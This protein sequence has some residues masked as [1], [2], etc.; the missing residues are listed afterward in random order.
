MSI[1]VINYVLDDKDWKK[2]KD[3]LELLG[4]SGRNYMLDTQKTANAL[5][6]E[7]LY[8]GRIDD[9]LEKIGEGKIITVSFDVKSATGNYLLVY[10]N[11]HRHKWYFSV[12]ETTF[13]G[14]SFRNFGT[15][16]VRLSFKAKVMFS[17]D[18]V[19]N[20]G[21]TKIEFF[22]EYN[23]GNFFQIKNVKI[24]KGDQKT[25]YLP[26]PEDLGVHPF[27]AEL[28]ELQYETK[29]NKERLD[30]LEKATVNLGGVV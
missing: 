5:T 20:H 8:F 10:N 3:D 11:N 24:E 26:A 7:H 2:A 17:E 4:E 30:E 29:R 13:N 23:T 9:A 22:G 16:W 28:A 19:T 27:I 1:D 18:A 14:M 6:R 12:P 15:E 21:D 25:P